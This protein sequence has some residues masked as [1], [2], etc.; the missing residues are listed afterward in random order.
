MT[1]KMNNNRFMN[2]SPSNEI[3]MTANDTILFNIT[4]KL[5]VLAF[6]PLFVTQIDFLVEIVLALITQND[7]DTL[8]DIDAKMTSSVLV[9]VYLFDAMCSIWCTYMIYTIDNAQL[10]Y[11]RCCFFCDKQ[12]KAIAQGRFNKEASDT[13]YFEFHQ[14]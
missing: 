12:C 13:S 3:K 8:Q 1:Q 4:A 5:T 11:K 9:F 2:L 14:E 6:L 10:W 7:D